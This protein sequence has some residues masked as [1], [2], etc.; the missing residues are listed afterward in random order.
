MVQ[1]EQQSQQSMQLNAQHGSASDQLQQ[2]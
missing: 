1:Q 2:M